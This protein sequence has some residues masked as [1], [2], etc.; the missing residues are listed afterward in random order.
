MNRA[1]PAALWD[2]ALPAALMDRALPTALRGRAL[3]AADLVD[4]EAIY[5]DDFVALSAALRVRALPAAHR[6]RSL[7]VAQRVRT[8]PVARD[9]VP[10]PSATFHGSGVGPV[11]A[12]PAPVSHP[13]MQHVS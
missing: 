4:F 9:R 5:F 6:T 7:P 10:V 2:R 12:S 13:C 11:S 1:Q 3:P 8:L